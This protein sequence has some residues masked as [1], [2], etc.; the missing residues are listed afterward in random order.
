MK[1]R[2]SRFNACVLLFGVAWGGWGCHTGS[3]Q[4]KAPKKCRGRV[5][6]PARERKNIRAVLK[7]PRPFGAAGEG[8][9]VRGITLPALLSG[10]V[11]MRYRV[12][13]LCSA[14]L[15]AA[16]SLAAGA[17][18][19]KSDVKGIFLLTDYPAVTLRPGSTPAIT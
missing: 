14:V 5:L 11:T 7:H 1:F 17:E 9:L 13:A 4:K 12:I 10:A 2:L 16:L 18:E 6:L 19:S 3:G 15:L 8:V